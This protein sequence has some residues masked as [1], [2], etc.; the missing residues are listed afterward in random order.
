[1]AILLQRVKFQHKIHFC[2]NTAIL[3]AV[4]LLTEQWD[5]I[6]HSGCNHQPTEIRMT[7]V[8]R[9]QKS[10]FLNT[11]WP[12]G[13]ILPVI[14]CIGNGYGVD[15]QSIGAKETIS[16]LQY[17]F[18]TFGLEWTPSAYIFYV[19]GVEKWRT[20]TAI[21]HTSEYLIFSQEITGFGGDRFAG[22]YPDFMD[23]DWVKVY[24]TR[25]ASVFQDCQYKGWAKQ[26]AIGNYTMAQLA[27]LGVTNDAISSISVPAG[28][29]IQLYQG[30]NFT[31]SSITLTA[32]NNCLIDEAFD[33][34]VSSLKVSA[35]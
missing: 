16:G 4:C 1:M 10:I 32:D 27:A 34:N 9:E 3:N 35:N 28:I 31:G 11:T 24:K 8:F 17:G 5:R 12:T 19:D 20:S 26:L 33:D 21:S 15:H 25:K 23:I 2:R 18:H 7:L 13:P 30:D 22:T 29:K 6:V 14:I